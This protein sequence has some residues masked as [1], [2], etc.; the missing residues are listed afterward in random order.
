MPANP[1]AFAPKARPLSEMDAL[2]APRRWSP[3]TFADYQPKY[4]EV[5]L[6]NA[7]SR[8]MDAK[9]ESRGLV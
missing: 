4:E 8:I 6:D 9:R 3:C 2:M 7:L 1:V 5:A